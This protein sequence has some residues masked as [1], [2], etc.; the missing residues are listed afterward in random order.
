MLMLLVCMVSFVSCS[1]DDD[2][3]GNGKNDTSQLIVTGSVDDKGDTWAELEGYLNNTDA[4]GNVTVSVAEYGIEVCL[5]DGSNEKRIASKN[6][7][8]SEFSVKV[9]GLTS[10][11]SYKYRAYANIGTKSAPEYKYGK[12]KKF[13]TEKGS[14]EPSDPNVLDISSGE[15]TANGVLFEGLYYTFDGSKATI[16]KADPSL[17]SVKLTLKVKHSGNVYDLTAIGDKAFQNCSQLKS[18]DLTYA[19]TSVGASAFSG[20]SSLEKITLPA[21]LKEIKANTFQYCTKL[22]NVEFPTGLVKIGDYAF[23]NTGLKNLSL[24]SNVTEIG[25]LSFCETK[26]E[27]LYLGSKLKEIPEKAFMDCYSLKSLT[28]TAPITKLGNASFA[29]CTHLVDIDLPTSLVEIGPDCFEWNQA[30]SFVFIPKG[31]QTIDAGAFSYCSKL[32]RVDISTGIKTIGSYAFYDTP[33]NITMQITASTPPS[34]G[35]EAF[36]ELNSYDNQ[37]TLMV[38]SSYLST[39]SSNSTYKKYFKTIKAS[40]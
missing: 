38:P 1:K 26:I 35:T 40:E 23:Y 32:S 14:G 31:V 34:L 30:L 4:D 28:I 25:K 33:K 15:V 36:K 20:C 22:S 8:E 24:P 27:S 5:E 3:E 7:S 6:L 17:T 37:R 21:S 11:T 2:K 13:T 12:Y 18:I 29:Y 9:T 16:V 19:I 10:N 39:Y